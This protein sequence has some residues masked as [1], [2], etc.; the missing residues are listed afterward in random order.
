VLFFHGLEAKTMQAVYSSARAL[1]FP[2]LAEGF[3]WPLVEAQACGCPVITTDEP[4]MNEV[5][6]DAAYLLPRLRSYAE[7]DEWASNGAT[8]LQ[9]LLAEDAGQQMR[10]AER[11]RAW[12]RRFDADKAIEGYL[13]IYKRVLDVQ[14]IKSG[15]EPRLK[16]GTPV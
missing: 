14:A 5:A 3:G 8:V 10:R 16:Q 7:V 9:T 12:V 13:A 6:G 15:I 2:S 11:G 4:P 1:L